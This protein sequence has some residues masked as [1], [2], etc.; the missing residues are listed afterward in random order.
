MKFQSAPTPKGGRYAVFLTELIQA[1]EFQS[2]PTPKG[3]RYLAGQRT[4]VSL[5]FQSAPTPKGGRYP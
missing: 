3:G 5:M 4:S 1:I 2:A